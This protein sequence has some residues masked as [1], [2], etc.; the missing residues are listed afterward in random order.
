M[1]FDVVCTG[2]VFL[3][4][5]FEG[6]D[7]L[8]AP[9]RERF[10]LELHETPG[11]SAITA[12]GLARL[13]LR[14]AVAAPLGSDVAGTTVSRLLEAEGVSSA[15]TTGGRTAV[16][17]VLPLDGERAF[18]TYEPSARVDPALVER[19]QPRAV[20]VG[21]DQ[22]HLIPDDTFAYVVV[23]DREAERYAGAL[24]REV[25][26][27]RA[28]LANRSE[29]ERLTGEGDAE[30]AA[31]ALAEHVPVAVVSC[32]AVG[33]VA[34]CDGNVFDCPAP[35]VE[36]RDTTG[37]GDLLAAAYVWGDLEGLPLVERLRRAVVYSALSVRA[38]TGVAGAAT[39]DELERALAELDPAIMQTASVKEGA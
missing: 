32:G 34:A 38:A 23:G 5:T 2:P 13:G 36:V 33:A 11:G 16:T 30:A 21:L 6:L 31:L 8:P 20:I 28:L 3:D 39:Y 1:T 9:G 7:E 19:L 10:A 35:R 22:L 17:A 24:P 29:A 18:V 12:V 4:L 25:R 14:V 15:N 27:V 37:A 26:R